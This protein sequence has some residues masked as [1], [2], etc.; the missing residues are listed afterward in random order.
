MSQITS[1]YIFLDITIFPHQILKISFLCGDNYSFEFKPSWLADS[2]KASSLLYDYLRRFEP[3]RRGKLVTDA[4]DQQPFEPVEWGLRV[5]LSGHFCAS[6]YVGQA[7]RKQ[8]GIE[9][10]E[11][12]LEAQIKTNKIKL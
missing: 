2:I 5:V 8:A 6:L 1:C 10:Q 4:R 3:T 9:L 12:L 11:Y 7:R